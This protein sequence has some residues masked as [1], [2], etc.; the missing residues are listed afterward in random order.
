MSRRRA[1]S[2]GDYSDCSKDNDYQEQIDSCSDNEKVA[3]AKDVNNSSIESNVLGKDI[4]NVHAE[5]VSAN[6]VNT[7]PEAY[8]EQFAGKN[9]KTRS[10]ADRWDPYYMATGKYFSHDNREANE[11]INIQISPFKN[12]F[13]KLK[14]IV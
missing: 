14:G 9:S 5:I 10:V 1:L 11:S 12:N 4:Y 7:P 6:Y 13:E 3:N 2:E 8:N